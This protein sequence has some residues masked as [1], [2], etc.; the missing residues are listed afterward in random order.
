MNPIAFF[1]TVHVGGLVYGQPCHTDMKEYGMCPYTV[2]MHWNHENGVDTSN[3][4]V[5][6]CVVITQLTLYHPQIMEVSFLVCN[7]LK[8]TLD[9]VPIGFRLKIS[10]RT[11]TAMLSTLMILTTPTH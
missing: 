9:K 7:L 4:E 1:L 3:Q 10:H 8:H 11:A 2:C 6:S 5:M